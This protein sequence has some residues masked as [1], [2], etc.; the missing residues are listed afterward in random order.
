MTEQHFD[1]VGVGANSVDYVYCLPEFPRP[2]GPASKLRISRHAVLCGG[3]TTTALCT[4][5][6]MGLRTKY[7]GAIGNDGNGARM[8]RE[9]QRRGVDIEHAYVRDVPN[10]FAVILIDGRRGERVVLWDRDAALQLRPGEIDTAIVAGSRLIHVDDADEDAAI[11]AAARGRSAGIPVTSDIERVTERTEELIAAVTIPIFAEHV[12]EPLTGE[13]DVERALRAVRRQRVRL[14]ASAKASAVRRSFTRRRKPDT[15]YEHDM[16]CVTLGARGA[17]LLEGDRLH[18]VPGCQVEVIDTTGAGDV[19]RGA[20]ITALLRGDSP[21]SILRFANA[22][23]A[24]SCTRLGAMDG[25]P[26]AEE[27]IALAGQ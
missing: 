25:V 27:T 16:L 8:R 11:R 26:T 23:A 14:T 9:L 19:F 3:Q 15:T 2:D 24:I 18:Q 1:V 22:A 5:A 20:F 17:M 12:L 7:V 6:A 13:R 4:C 21:A 10:P